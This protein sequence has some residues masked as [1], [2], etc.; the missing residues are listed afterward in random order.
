MLL[1]TH[2]PKKGAKIGLLARNPEALNAAR[3]E[4]E[5]LGGTALALPS[6][7]SD[8]N[9]VEEAATRI[10]AEFGPIDIWVN[11]AMVSVFFTGQRN[12]VERLSTSHRSVVPRI[13][14]R[15]SL[16]PETHAAA[17]SR[18]DYS[19]RVRSILSLHS[20]A[21]RILRLKACN[22]RIH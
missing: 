12:G 3:S 13:R 15:D 5:A 6:N 10:E 4:C 11:D 16:G 22:Q 1:L 7:V 14:A 21:I 2:S 17:R 20:I 19:N 18:S 8:A 9:S